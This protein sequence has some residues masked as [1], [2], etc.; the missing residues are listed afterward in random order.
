M[1]RRLT[2]RDVIRAAG[3]AWVAS[4]A[5]PAAAELLLAPPGALAAT[6]CARLTPEL[7][8]GPFWV[9]AM[10]RRF[11]VRAS[12]S[13][14]ASSRQAGVPLDLHINIVDSSER[15]APLN[16]VAVDIWHA[17]A[18]GLYSDEQGQSAGGCTSAAAGN[19]SG[20]NGF[21]ATRSPATTAAC[22][23]SRSL[24][25][26]ASARSG[27]AGMRDGRST[28]TCACGASRAPARRSRATRPRSS[29]RTPTTTAC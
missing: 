29:S 1:G 8:E 13:A 27:R 11:D 16:G 25:R 5:L 17:N 22:V 24:A 20:E 15:C 6:R 14:P 3:G 10:P 18:H 19:T 28:S 26:S 2:R 4:L 9:P 12:T 7:T 21:S 23:R